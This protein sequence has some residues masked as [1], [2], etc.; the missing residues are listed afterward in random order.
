M[1][2]TGRLILERIYYDVW[3]MDA[4]T[5]EIEEVIKCFPDS[6]AGNEIVAQ[7]YRSKGNLEKA[8]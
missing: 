5:R 4:A 7:I 8:F 1:N 6:L 3:M 2:F